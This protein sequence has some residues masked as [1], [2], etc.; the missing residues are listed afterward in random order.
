MERAIGRRRFVLVVGT[1]WVVAS[2]C[3]GTGA[4]DAAGLDAARVDAARRD[5]GT[6]DARATDAGTAWSPG[7]IQLVIGERTS[8]DLAA[9]LPAG[10]TL[11]GTFAVAP[12]G[13]ALPTGM[14]LGPDGV[15]RLGTA[16][17][18]I[19]DGVLF[20]YVEP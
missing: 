14:T 10:V 19:T 6:V 9:T 18:G 15:L 11:G 2:G 8:V 1:G 5:A 12:E 16:T 20:D 13:T 4:P 17:V 3:D 7:T